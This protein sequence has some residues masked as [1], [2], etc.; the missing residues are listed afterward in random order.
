MTF[1]FR[2]RVE[3][4]AVYAYCSPPHVRILHALRS[5]DGRVMEEMEWSWDGSWLKQSEA[6]AYSWEYGIERDW[7]K[8]MAQGAQTEC[9]ELSIL[10]ECL[11]AQL[12]DEVREKVVAQRAVYRQ[13]ALEGNGSLFDSCVTLRCVRTENMHRVALSIAPSGRMEIRLPNIPP[14]NGWYLV[15]ELNREYAKQLRRQVTQVLADALA[16]A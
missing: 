15:D 10:Y 13:L 14:T 1:G 3:G 12:C 9:E 5:Y 7:L 11:I 6:A 2:Q 4:Y 16:F 8:R